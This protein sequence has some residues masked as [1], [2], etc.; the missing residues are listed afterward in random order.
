MKDPFKKLSKDFKEETEKLDEIQLRA[1]LAKITLDLE[2]M[3]EAKEN[4]YDLAQKRE[5]YAFAGAGYREFAKGGKLMIKWLRHMLDAKG[6]DT[7]S[8]DEDTSEPNE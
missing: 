4:D 5:A 8:Y 7:G 2:A 3:A 1:R 6:K